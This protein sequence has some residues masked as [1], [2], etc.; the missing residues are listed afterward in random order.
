MLSARAPNI[1]QDR[2]ADFLARAGASKTPGRAGALMSTGLKSALRKEN[3]RQAPKTT[4]A[5]SKATINLVDESIE[6]KRLFKEA[7]SK[8][9]LGKGLS[10]VT[11]K[12]PAP[13]KRQP[14]AFKTP[15]PGM[16]KPLKLAPLLSADA[17]PEVGPSPGRASL[18]PPPSALRPS[19]SRR[20]SRIIRS[21]S[22]S[23]ET[24]LPSSRKHWDVSDGDISVAALSDVS[25]KE[26][27]NEGEEDEIEYMPPTAW[28]EPYEPP[29][30][31]P[32]Y[33]TLCPKLLEIARIPAFGDPN[34]DMF[35]DS[36]L[37]TWVP[38][39]CSVEECRIPLR[40][41]QEEEFFGPPIE[42]PKPSV[43]RLA[44]ANRMAKSRASR[45]MSITASRLGVPRSQAS[46][47]LSRPTSRPLSAKPV[48]SRPHSSS[49][50]PSVR[51]I[52]IQ[53]PLNPVKP[54]GLTRR[55]SSKP[56]PKVEAQK[57]P[58]PSDT[59][60]VFM[61]PPE[62]AALDEDFMFDV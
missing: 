46:S 28:I 40:P 6:P 49:L 36:F 52:P 59:L 9:P 42:L 15:L 55:A 51:T 32:D 45:D 62:F 12:T 17:A 47:A 20:T 34:E 35:D 14:L 3:S 19:S 56:L 10:D 16:S 18:E 24:P 21:S 7:S 58:N 4:L 53:Q 38:P 25:I 33:K 60:E 37:E 13:G 30:P 57:A 54:G 5:R 11:N 61:A 39:E 8:L 27:A 43:G 50:K 31:L 29:F 41:L 2:Q 44:A 22:K 26:A 48:P 23:F 1:L